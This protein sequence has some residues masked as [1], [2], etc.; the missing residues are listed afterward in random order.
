VTSFRWIGSAVLLASLALVA[1][2][3][4]DTMVFVK[5]SNVWIARDDGSRQVRLTRD[6][7]RRRPYFSPT[8]ADNGTIVALKGIHLYS[9]K[10]NGRRIVRPRQW[11]INPSVSISTEPFSVD[12]SPNGRIVAT[13]NG[14]YS[15]YYDPRTSAI[16]PT[17]AAQFVDFFDFRKNKEV[18]KTDAY[19][20]YGLPSW[21][22]SRHVLTTSYGIF[23][24][25]VL[26]AA[27]GAST[28]GADFFR[29]P[30]RDPATGTNA[31]VIADAEATRARD[32]F[33]VMRRPLQGAD[34]ADLSVATIQIY[35][36]GAPPTAS[37]PLCTIGPGRSLDYDADPSWSTDGKRLVWWE[38]GK[39]IFA[40]PVTDAPGCGLKVR[41]IVR[42]GLSP[43]V[44][45]AKLPRRRR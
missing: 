26:I 21:I 35:R 27:V 5:K 19:Y 14:I 37:T 44:S 17:L 40:T 18:G 41:R 2:A 23:N 31:F 43:D 6:G 24:A 45:K 16:R 13:H 34:A 22:D 15:T 20:D 30:N 9:F 25:Q 12:L 29:D 36:T 32:R 3:Q 11:A 38:R 42:G 1:P 4:A 33:A 10:P 28:R 8:V 7:T 39:G